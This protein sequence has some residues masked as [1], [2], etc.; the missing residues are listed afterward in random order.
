MSRRLRSVLAS[1]YLLL[2]LPPLFWAC[3]WVV[4]RAFSA[5]IP[6][7]AMTFYRW[8]CAALMLAPFAWPRLRRAWPTLRAHAWLFV[9]LGIIGA[10]LQNGLAYVGLNF[11]TATNGVILNSFIPVM[12]VACSWVFLHER[13][14]ARQLAGVGISLT[15]VLTI[16]AQGSLAT[17]AHLQVNIGDLLIL[18]SM[19]T[20]AAYTLLL[21]KRPPAIDTV[22]F[23]FVIAAVGALGALPLYIAETHWYK[24]MTWSGVH[25]IVV[26]SV[27]LFS[28]VLAYLFWNLG[29]ER[30]GAS[31]AGLFVHLM[32]VF[33]VLLAW[34]FLGEQLA[35]F[36]VA[37]IAL[38]LAGIFITRRGAPRP[39]NAG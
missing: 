11:T 3:N 25:V 38:I 26:L 20:W 27:A 6:P 2:S 36:H 30:V 35:L 1:P 31:V 10:T 18:V 34:L 23:I 24:P 37:G 9:L 13:L 33:G 21:R 12:I 28:S 8:A 4:G 7:M 17:L 14:A 19:G 22:L 32:P 15:G 16:L 5:E 39:A 29:V